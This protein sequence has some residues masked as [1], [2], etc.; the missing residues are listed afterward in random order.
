MEITRSELYRLVCEKPLSKVA[1]EF[2]ISGTALSVLCKKHNVPYPGSGHWTRISLG[3]PVSIQ[4]LPPDEHETIEIPAAKPKRTMVKAKPE[5][6]KPSDDGQVVVKQRLL[7]PHPIIAGWLEKR[8]RHRRDRRDPYGRE[9]P[10]WTELDRRRHRLLDATFK[11]LE[12]RGGS[13]SDS[14]NGNQCVAI[15]GEK[16]EFQIREKMRHSKVAVPDS[17][18]LYYSRGFRTDLVGTGYLVFAIKTYLR[19]PYNEEYLESDRRPLEE[20]LP[21]IIDRL[22]EG[23]SI[24]KAWHLEQEQEREKWRQEAARRAELQRLAEEEEERWSRFTAAATTWKTTQAVAQ[25]ITELEATPYADDDAVGGRSVR[26]WLDWAK[27]KAA[28]QNPLGN[29]MSELF[30]RIDGGTAHFS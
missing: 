15:D 9:P 2:G 4:P 26:E 14:G 25:F 21:R 27:R 23:A 1:P 30:R 29:G 18:K 8:E 3:M 28:E 6:V 7:K 5:E 24:L 17:E 19:G 16:I 10:A 20:R 12:A 22:F 11:A 13:V